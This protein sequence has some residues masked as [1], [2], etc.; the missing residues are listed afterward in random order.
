MK[1]PIV[2]F[3]ISRKLSM[4]LV[5]TLGAIPA[6]AMPLTSTGG[7]TAFWISAVDLKVARIVPASEKLR[8]HEEEEGEKDDEKEEKKGPVTRMRTEQQD[9]SIFDEHFREKRPQTDDSL[10][11]LIALDLPTGTITGPGAQIGPVAQAMDEVSAR[12]RAAKALCGG[13][14]S[15]YRIDCLADQFALVANDLPATGELGDLKI[16]LSSA[17]KE[18]AKIARK[19]RDPRAARVRPI[20]NTIPGQPQASRALRAVREMR[21]AQAEQQALA[22]V[23]QLATVLLRSADTATRNSIYIAR[24][25]QAVDSNKILLRSA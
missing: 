4:V 21:Q 23:D 10:E 11:D 5:A 9:N 19:N 3:S 25:A 1:N 16:A 24:I 18:L 12:V 2:T 22:V 15:V 6:M 8:I 7:E 20:S 17:A 13:I 14:P